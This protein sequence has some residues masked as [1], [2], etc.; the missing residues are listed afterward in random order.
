MYYNNNGIPTFYNWTVNPQY[1]NQQAYN[2]Y[3]AQI[4]AYECQQNI[5]VIKTANK[6]KEYLDAAQK[7]DDN[8][9]QE[10]FFACLAVI[11]DKMNWN[12]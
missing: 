6:F 2:Q 3:Q 8:H 12:N 5:E 9:K 4:Q 7:V 10:L 1:I 11:A